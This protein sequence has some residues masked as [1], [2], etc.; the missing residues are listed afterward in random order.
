[1]LVYTMHSEYQVYEWVCSIY[2]IHSQDYGDD[3]EMVGRRELRG[4]SSEFTTVEVCKINH[5]HT[6][7]H[8][9][10]FF[11]NRSNKVA[12]VLY[13]NI[14]FSTHTVIYYLIH[15]HTNM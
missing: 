4:L 15:T 9:E 1:M 12:T 2:K 3:C 10:D 13:R 11:S 6:H 7:T 14:Q 5:T 8:T